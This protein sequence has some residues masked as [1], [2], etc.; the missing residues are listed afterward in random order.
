MDDIDCDFELDLDPNGVCRICMSETNK[1]LN[2]NS[3]SVVDGYVTS[4]PEM[5]RCCLDIK[6]IINDCYVLFK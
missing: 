5:V 1:L 4:V 2:L 6:V 3:H